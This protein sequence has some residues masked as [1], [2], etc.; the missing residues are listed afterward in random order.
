[1]DLTPFA[2]DLPSEAGPRRIGLVITTYNRPD[3]LR[4]ALRSLAR[5]D[6]SAAALALVDDGSDDRRTIE[7]LDSWQM[8]GIPVVK[9]RRRQHAGAG[10]AENLE[11]AF[12]LL[13]NQFDCELLA[14]LDSDTVVKRDWLARM[15]RLWDE[16][17]GRYPCAIVTGFNA[18]SPVHPVEV[19]YGDY[20]V[21]SSVGGIS[22]LFD[23]KTMAQIVRP[24]LNAGIHWDMRV[25][26]LVQQLGGVFLCTRPSVVEHL[27]RIGYYSTPDFHDF[28]S[29]YWGT[30]R[31]ARR[32]ARTYYRL[33]GRLQERSRAQ[34]DHPPKPDRLFRLTHWLHLRATHAVVRYARFVHRHPELPPKLKRPLRTGASTLLELWA[35]DQAHLCGDHFRGYAHLF[36]HLR[37][38]ILD[39]A[40]CS[41]PLEPN[42]DHAHALELR[43]GFWQ[44]PSFAPVN[45]PLHHHLRW[46]TEIIR[47][48]EK[49][50]IVDE[51]SR[52]TL[53]IRRH[54]Y[55]HLFFML[56]E[57]YNAFL[58]ARFFGWDPDDMQVILADDHPA[59]PLD[60][61]WPTCFRR[62]L[63]PQQLTGRH[64]FADL[65]FSLPAYQSPLRV[66]HPTAIPLIDQFR[67]FVLGRFGIQPPYVR[68]PSR[69][70][71][72]LIIERRDY[73][74]EGK[75]V[76]R[77]IGRKISNPNLLQELRS[78]FPD[79]QI[80]ATPLE[81]LSL[82][83][84]VGLMQKTDVL[85][86][87]H[88][89]GLAGLLFLPVWAG[90]IELSPASAHGY[91]NTVYLN[92]AMQLGLRYESWTNTD[93][94][95]Q[96]EEDNTFVPCEAVARRLAPLLAEITG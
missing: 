38:A 62:V 66:F 71:S 63:K 61:L 57:V 3:Y 26:D 69:P 2:V 59:V 55:A 60:E 92:L 24:A 94:G 32:A 28:A 76:V 6:L 73:D 34:K 93:P 4:R 90:V 46:W 13:I 14:N 79:A 9:M 42:E 91:Q 81:S 56:C 35:A 41:V 85:I 70:L 75:G 53:A 29:D 54:E 88:G 48:G 49:E 51:H 58:M 16:Q 84:Q 30:H 89:A 36:A 96:D 39:P 31:V 43:A 86:G 7:I 72:V 19:E 5:S 8:P 65:V 33:T 68:D 18:D 21:K 27:G 83:E 82:A 50:T 47:Q 22:F 74:V 40:F 11:A 25:V 95:R 78:Q 80:Q 64:W 1:M 23:R 87:M 12:N 17:R 45:Y 37:E 20:Y 67:L 52:P 10:I 44:L 77:R 15:V